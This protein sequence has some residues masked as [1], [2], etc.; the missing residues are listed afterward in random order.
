MEQKVDFSSEPNGE[1]KHADV[2]IQN[3]SKSL[4]AA[5][6]RR[7]TFLPEPSIW[8]VQTGPSPLQ[9]ESAIKE[10]KDVAL[11]VTVTHRFIVMPWWQSP[12]V[13]HSE[14]KP[15]IID[16]SFHTASY[17]TDPAEGSFSFP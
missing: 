17:K 8:K 11:I 15:V 5:C 16:F 14:P 4:L 6:Q 12:N 9:A 13:L 10:I 2:D 1:Y 7:L 3:T